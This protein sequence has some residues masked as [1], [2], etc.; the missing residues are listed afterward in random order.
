MNDTIEKSLADIAVLFDSA[1]I[2]WGVGA[3]MLLHQYGLV[4]SPADI[5]IVVSLK[6]IAKVDELFS[7][8]GISKII[9]EKSAVYSTDFFYEYVF[10]NTD[11][12][13]MA[14]FKINL[15]GG[16]YEYIFD[17]QSIPHTFPIKG[18]DVPFMT[19]EEWYILY[20][21][22]PGR[23]TKVKLIEDYFLENGI[24][25]SGLLIR[26]LDAEAIPQKVKDRIGEILN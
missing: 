23:E 20:Q 18:I 13:V 5:D 4:E 14:G 19:L 22:M 12:D 16:I 2:T 25:Y 26:A 6:D 3:S 15:P 1:G 24:Q 8:K 11:V 21:L 9:K 17:D 7:K 10:N